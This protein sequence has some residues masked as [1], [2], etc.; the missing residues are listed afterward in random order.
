MHCLLH[1]P[2]V[3]N[4][5]LHQAARYGHKEVAALLLDRGANLEAVNKVSSLGG[6]WG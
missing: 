6:M 3:G 5:P 4:T 1:G 2:Q